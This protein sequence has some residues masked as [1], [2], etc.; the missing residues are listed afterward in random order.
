MSSLGLAPNSEPCPIL[1]FF[2]FI[3]ASFDAKGSLDGARKENQTKAQI[4][5]SCTM[6]LNAKRRLEGAQRIELKPK[7]NLGC[8]A[9]IFLQLDLL[10][11]IFF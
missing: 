6:S 4:F 3:K 11:S 2:F 5:S 9:L 8:F 7:E 10:N 1:V